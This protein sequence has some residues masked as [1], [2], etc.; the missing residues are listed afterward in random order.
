[1]PALVSEPSLEINGPGGRYNVSNPLYE[2]AF[3]PQPPSAE[4]PP[5][6]YVS[7]EF[8]DRRSSR[9]IS[10]IRMLP[11]W[12]LCPCLFSSPLFRLLC[13]SMGKDLAEGYTQLARFPRTVRYPDNLGNSQP[14]LVNRQ[15]V[16]N[17]PSYVGKDPAFGITV[18]SRC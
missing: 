3:H 13:A 2:Y 6:D 15:L 4:F 10:S 14:A 5:G 11:I 1:M 17:G 7:A 12:L 16:A 8:S 9:D 18:S